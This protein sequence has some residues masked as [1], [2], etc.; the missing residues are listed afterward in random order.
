[1]G[2]PVKDRH[3]GGE[4]PTKL[5]IP[6]QFV[7]GEEFGMQDCSQ[8]DSVVNVDALLAELAAVGAK[9]KG[10]DAVEKLAG[11]A[12]FR[13]KLLDQ[14][15]VPDDLIGGV[16]GD[17]RFGGRGTKDLASRTWIAKDVEFAAWGD[18]AA[19]MDR[20]T[21]D[22]EPPNLRNDTGVALNG[23]GDVGKG[24]QA[25]ER[26]F[27]RGGSNFVANELYGRMLARMLRD[28]QAGIS[29]AVFAMNM[30]RVETGGIVGGG[31]RANSG[32]AGRIELLDERLDVQRGVLGGDISR[33]SRDGND[34]QTRIK[35]RHG[36]CDGVVDPRI[37]VDNHFASHVPIVEEIKPL[38]NVASI[39][40]VRKRRLQP[41]MTVS[42]LATCHRSRILPM[43]VQMQLSRI[44]ISEIYDQQ[45]IYLREVEG[46]RQFPIVIGMPE[47]K[48]ID[49]GVKRLESPRP[50]T[51]ELLI[52]V[53][54]A[55]GGELDSVEISELRDHIYFAKLRVRKDGEMVEID[56]RPSDAI[57]V[58]VA[59]NPALPIYVAEEVLDET[60]SGE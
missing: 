6:V 58:A 1:M 28:I 53:I 13:G 24:P 14:L 27:A 49:A 57:A 34:L 48:S 21:H 39:R 56:S 43:T 25:K 30:A 33:H 31:G 35:E 59:C 3:A 40:G 60:T 46:E 38:G 23:A 16:Q 26:D 5:H 47:A 11:P 51:H 37:A 44:I 4:F 17:Q 50:R 8:S 42:T 45:I 20:P 29:Q 54:E 36:Q 7:G 15:Q 12:A 18:I 22:D 9:E 2:P 19:S 41:I 55:L 10:D 52:G 32:K